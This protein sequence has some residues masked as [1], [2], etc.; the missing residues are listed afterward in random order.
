MAGVNGLIALHRLK[1]GFISIG[2]RP[3]ATREL[4]RY[5]S[6]DPV[7]FGHK[8]DHISATRFRRAYLPARLSFLAIFL[9][10]SRR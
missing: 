9:L 10:L 8:P 1:R 6:L 3:G 7:D 2:C 4:R 5:Q